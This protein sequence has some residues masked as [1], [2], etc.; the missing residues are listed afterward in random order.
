MPTKTKHNARKGKKGKGGKP[1]P[2]PLTLANADRHALYEAAVQN[3]ESEIDFVDEQFRK[4]RGRDGVSLREDFCGTGNSACEWVRRRETNTAVGLDLD[5]E[6]LDW[7]LAHHVA[8]LDEGQRARVRLL[9]RDVR[10][11]GDAVGL[12]IILAMNFSYWLF[13]H[14]AEM[15]EYFRAVRESLADDGVFFLDH[16][17]G[18]EAMQEQEEERECELADGRKFT[19]IWDQHK[20]EP[21][22]GRVENYIHFEFPDGTKMKKAYTYPWRLWSLP[23]V[24]DVL[25]DAGFSKVTVYWE[26]DD[27]ESDG[28]N[29]EFEAATEGENCPAF[30]SYI[31]A[32]K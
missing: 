18:Y 2:S 4:M 25:R 26:G 14:R 9:E 31:T 24:Q 17:G 28:G 6:T 3:V 10:S 32:E 8:S 23:E 27:D 1:K 29:G 30:V 19:Y 7:G 21:I 15:L 16:Y 22:T 11:P 20:I 13:M 12:D 5:R